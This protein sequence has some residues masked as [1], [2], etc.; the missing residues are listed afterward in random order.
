MTDI[1]RGNFKSGDF[2]A[3]GRPALILATAVATALVIWLGT[4]VL[5]RVII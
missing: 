4:K 2:D 3:Q 5:P 1:F